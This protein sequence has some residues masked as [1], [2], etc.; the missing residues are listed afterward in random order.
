[1]ATG[2]QWEI[3]GLPSPLDAPPEQ[4][5]FLSP[6]LNIR[7]PTPVTLPWLVHLPKAS[8]VADSSKKP[9][10]TTSATHPQLPRDL[11]TGSGAAPG[12]VSL[13]CSLPPPLS[14][15]LELEIASKL[16][17]ATPAPRTWSPHALLCLHTGLD[18]QCVSP[19]PA[20]RPA[21]RT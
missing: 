10:Q 18:P 15:L 6:W 21:A 1:M 12:S 14:P 17:F 19:V 20:V 4:N 7:H 2:T 9:S 11:L 13:G 16:A 8:P 3:Q 5:A